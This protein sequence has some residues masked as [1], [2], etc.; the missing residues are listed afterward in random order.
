VLLSATQEGPLCSPG[1]A[2]WPCSCGRACRF[3]EEVAHSAVQFVSSKFTSRVGFNSWLSEAVCLLRQICD[4]CREDNESVF[5]NF[6][7][8]VPSQTLF[9]LR[10]FSFN[11]LYKALAAACY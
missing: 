7:I 4:L 6:N 8:T 10:G 11:P 3:H 1:F 2:M 9:T 5:R